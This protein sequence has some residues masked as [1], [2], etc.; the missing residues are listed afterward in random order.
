MASKI[1]LVFII[2]AILLCS[3]NFVPQQIIKSESQT[4]EEDTS[5]EISTS[6]SGEITNFPKVNTSITNYDLGK[7]STLYYL[8][9]TS[10]K[11]LNILCIPVIISD[12]S[13]NATQKVKDDIN[14]AFF[15]RSSNDNGWYS[16]SD[17]YKAT[18]Y[19]KINIRGVVSDW[20]NC[21]YS[22]KEIMDGGDNIYRTILDDSI[23]WY[24]Q[25]YG[26]TCQEF[27]ADSN[28]LIDGVFLINSA[29]DYKKDSTL[30]SDFWAFT[31]WGSRASSY[32][33]PKGCL[34]TWASYDFLYDGYENSLDSHTY[35]HEFGHMLGLEDYYSYNAKSTGEEYRPLGGTDMMDLNIGDQNAFSKFSMGLVEP[36]F[37]NKEGTLELKS[38]ASSGEC[39]LIPTKKGWNGTC[40]DEYILLELFSNTGTNAQDY[41]DGYKKRS[42]ILNPLK[43]DKCVGIRAYH[44][45]A[46][47]VS[48]SMSSGSQFQNITYI[49][50]LSEVSSTRYADKAHTNT[51]TGYDGSGTRVD[52]LN[53]INPSYRLITLLSSQGR[54]FGNSGY[55]LQ[56]ADLFLAN[57]GISSYNERSIA[58][59]FPEGKQ[60]NNGSEFAYTFN[61]ISCSSNSATIEFKAY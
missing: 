25:K 48:F 50:S 47:L 56:N 46:R 27:D 29:P 45:D 3:C 1:K 22:S 28:G 2:N 15:G 9:E 36:Y 31:S 30:S 61:V 59:Q 58:K 40:F 43:G 54:D 14:T 32:S 20:Y 26:T 41:N 12:Y 21:G 24:K 55:Y 8:P 52:S 23:E 60:S 17:Y 7:K 13:I 44:V 11:N 10:Y 49:N 33:S 18:S 35:V 37:I 39:V 53:Y 5:Q 16:L 34:Y 51:P 6:S 57:K 38:L 4:S 42:S 19:G